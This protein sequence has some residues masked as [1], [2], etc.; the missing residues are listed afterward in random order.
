MTTEGKNIHIIE[1]LGKKRD[2]K[3][4]LEKH[5]SQGKWK[6]YKKLWVGNGFTVGVDKIPM[7]SEFERA[8]EG[9]TDLDK[10]VVKLGELNKLTYEDLILLINKDSSIEKVAFGLIQNAK[11]PDFP[12]GNSKLD[13]DR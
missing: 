7:Q 8:L 12:E 11:S 3:S 4:W 10:K 5:L 13:W 9:S 2:W 1:F 6:G